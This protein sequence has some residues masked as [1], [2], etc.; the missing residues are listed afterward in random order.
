MTEH[1]ALWQWSRQ[2]LDYA[3]SDI[4]LLQLALTHRSV[5]QDEL[6]NG[7]PDGSGA[8]HELLKHNERLEFLGDAVL[9]LAISDLLYH[10]FPEAVEGE[11]SHWRATLVNTTA[12]SLISQSLE[13]GPWLRLGRGEALSGGRDKS[14]IL[15]N[16]LEAILGAVFLDG[17]WQ[18]V[19]GVT[20]RMF[21]S[22]LDRVVPGGLGKDFKTV[23][24]E[25]L[26]AAGAPL[27]RYHLEEVLGAP[28]ERRFCVVCQVN[29]ALF[30][31]GKGR[32]KRRAE[33]EAAREALLA[34]D[35]PMEEQEV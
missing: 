2:R 29:E 15:G 8:A 31:R 26:Q 18:G 7:T 4:T 34:M 5:A 10:R 6:E 9:D 25:R 35:R 1:D 21:A 27:P 23:L 24:Q 12:L 32:T 19:E 13:L 30:G 17:G 11:M 3:F 14:S 16:T 20:R 22:S 28:H 33:Q